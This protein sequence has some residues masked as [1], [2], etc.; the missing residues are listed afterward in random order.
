MV[1]MSD[2]SDECGRCEQEKNT[3]EHILRFD[4]D[5]DP[6]HAD[7]CASCVRIIQQ[8]ENAVRSIT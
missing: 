1:Y 6:E 8:S 3:T 5:R 4:D 2:Q 7:L